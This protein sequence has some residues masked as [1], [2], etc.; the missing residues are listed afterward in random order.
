MALIPCSECRREISSRAPACPHC[1][2]PVHVATRP[3]AECGQQIDASA[4]AC[5]NCGCSTSATEARTP[6]RSAPANPAPA[7]A[8]VIPA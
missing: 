6:G 3:C 8:T 1:G 7:A 5:P 4:V 2:C